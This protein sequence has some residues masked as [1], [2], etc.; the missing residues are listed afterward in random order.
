MNA[1]RNPGTKKK[2]KK[3]KQKKRDVGAVIKKL[4]VTSLHEDDITDVM[5]HCASAL[6]LRRAMVK[7]SSRTAAADC[8]YTKSGASSTVSLWSNGFKV[9]ETSE[10]DAKARGIPPCGG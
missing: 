9:G 10:D 4:D 6:K 5:L 7:T 3:A 1:A 2:A 8:C